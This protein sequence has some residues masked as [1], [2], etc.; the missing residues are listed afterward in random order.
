LSVYLVDD[1][2]TNLEQIVAALAAN[3]D[4][5]SDFDYALF[6]QDTLWG[7][8]IK[9]E[10]VEGDTPDLE[11]NDWHYHLIELSA[12]SIIALANIILTEAMKKRFLS[13]RV[14]ELLVSGVSSGQIDRA[15][16]RLKPDIASKIDQSMEAS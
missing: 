14:F 10:S 12:S 7:A 4:Y 15:K 2:Q 5:I 3:A 9:I 8:D 13:K 16:L 11:V 6:N 1:D